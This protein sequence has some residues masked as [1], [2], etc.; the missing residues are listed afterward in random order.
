MQVESRSDVQRIE[1]T[2]AHLRY[3]L[4]SKFHGGLKYRLWHLLF[5]KQ[6][7]LAISFER[8]VELSSFSAGDCAAKNVL[9]DGMSPLHTMQRKEPDSRARRHPAL[10]LDGMRIVHVE[11]DKETGIRVDAQ[12][13]DFSRSSISKSAPGTRRPPRIFLARAAKSGH[14]TCS[15]SGRSGTMRPSTLSRSRSSTVFPALSHSFRRRVSR[16]CRRLIDGAGIPTNVTHN[17]SRRQGARNVQQTIDPAVRGIVEPLYPVAP[18][19][20]SPGCMLAICA[21]IA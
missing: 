6:P 7:K 12:Y 14:S 17:V 8:R 2:A 4:A 19:A 10:R 11:R 21:V 16:S 3:I 1:G 9:R 13:L 18:T 5:Q 20:C 15:G